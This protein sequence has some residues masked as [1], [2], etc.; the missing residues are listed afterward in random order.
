MAK[1]VEYDYV[2]VGAGSAGCVLAKHPT[3]GHMK[4]IMIQKVRS[5]KC[6][7]SPSKSKLFLK[8]VI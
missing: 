2:I 3:G 5:L 8:M 4:K 1:L 7:H 6:L